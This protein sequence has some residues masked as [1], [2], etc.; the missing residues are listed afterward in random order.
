MGRLTTY[1]PANNPSLDAVAAA[2]L[3]RWPSGCGVLAKRTIG[4]RLRDLDQ[5]RTEWWR[6][7]SRQPIVRR[8]AEV[9]KLEDHDLAA[10][11]RPTV[12]AAHPASVPIATLGDLRPLRIDREDPCP[13]FPPQVLAPERWTRHC[14]FYPDAWSRD[15]VVAWHTHRDRTML[16]EARTWDDALT[17]LPW[18]GRVLLVLEAPT[19]RGF[20]ALADRPDLFLCVLAPLTIPSPQVDKP[21]VQIHSP[22]PHEWRAEL[23]AWVR[24]RGH[25]GGLQQKDASIDELLAEYDAWFDG[26]RDALELC[27]LFEQFNRNLSDPTEL[28]RRY[29]LSLCKHRE[30]ALAPRLS[31]L[32]EHGMTNLV[33]LAVAALHHHGRASGLPRARLEALVPS[34]AHT[35]GVEQAHA[36]LRAAKTVSPAL[37]RELLADLD[38]APHHFIADLCTAGVLARASDDALRF[39]PP[40]FAACLTHAAL[41]AIDASPLATWSNRL[42]QPVLAQHAIEALAADW[43]D[44]DYTRFDEILGAPPE[45]TLP[46][47][48]AIDACLRSAGLARL[49][50][51]EL[52]RERVA[53]LWRLLPAIIKPSRFGKLPD[54]RFVSDSN[55]WLLDTRGFALAVVLLAELLDPDERAPFET[56]WQ[57]D[58]SRDDVGQILD[59]IDKL[60]FAC[61][62]GPSELL[63]GLLRLA[64]RWLERCGYSRRPFGVEELFIPA[65]LVKEIL[66]TP[67]RDALEYLGNHRLAPQL[68]AL[69]RRHCELHG[70][71]FATVAERCWRG[72]NPGESHDR[73]HP[74]FWWARDRPDHARLPWQH[75]P[76][77]LIR[78][79][80]KPDLSTHSL[81]VF[82]NAWRLFGRPQW[83]AW[84]DILAD[85]DDRWNLDTAWQH[86]P[87]DVLFDALARGSLEHFGNEA[88]ARV[89]SR[90][91][92]ALLARLGELRRRRPTTAWRLL[93]TAPESHRET[94]LDLALAWLRDDPDQTRVYLGEVV[95]RRSLLAPRAWAALQPA[96]P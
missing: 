90:M 67:S 92:D 79:D 48:L 9:L 4:N 71:D 51:A 1:L 12:D 52:P 41:A 69:I 70:L 50:G 24:P 43:R 20:A 37:H 26:P 44:G 66:G 47:H 39:D 68:P 61:H 31:W 2:M 14:W 60:F 25:G 53:Q 96:P 6:S 38:P 54:P 85:S 73:R 11:L 56:I 3:K 62:T 17:V 94:C 59:P 40:W 83:D 91:N 74:W 49:L 15:L 13:G 18:S 93:R 21:W 35:R 58:L 80:Y 22:P 29:L 89:W 55:N 86:M 64:A 95:A 81:G 57:H 72:W 23:A 84:L 65:W 33:E 27:G 8:L 77:D 32:R 76:P 28:A 16:L 63:D 10:I 5:D 7:E 34:A 75:L 19:D 46:Q 82:P 42:I 78:G 87:D 36:R 88:D 30:E 45:S